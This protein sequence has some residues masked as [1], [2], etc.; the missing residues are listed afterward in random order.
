[1]ATTDTVDQDDD[2][3]LDTDLDDGQDVDDERERVQLPARAGGPVAGGAPP[4]AF[5]A[6]RLPGEG[7]LVIDQAEDPSGEK[8]TADQPGVASRGVPG[9]EAL[10][11]VAAGA[12]GGCPGR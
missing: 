12:G 5:T 11:L 9:R 10:R 6:A 1:M 4:A 3:D 7:G 8:K 2:Q